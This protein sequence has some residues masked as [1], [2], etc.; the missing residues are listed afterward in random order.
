MSNVDVKNSLRLYLKKLL[1]YFFQGMIVLAP[2]GITLWVVVGLFRWIDGFLP[3][4]INSLFPDLLE[5][6]AAGNLRSLPGLGF[7]VVVA[8]VLLVGWISSLFVVGRLVTLLDTVLEKTPGIKFIYSSVK[9]FLEAFAGNKKKFDKPV[10]VNVD[11][12]DIWRIG[13]ITQQSSEEF[14]LKD[15]VTV[16]VPHSYAISGITYFVPK[17]KIK[18]LPSI[19]AADAMKYTVSGGVTEVE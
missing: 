12:A 17:E 13:F 1:Q 11:G 18:P 2:I 4:L 15:H 14:G 10:L 5:K 8:L 6:D 3:N 16:Y 9:D 19:S 7:I